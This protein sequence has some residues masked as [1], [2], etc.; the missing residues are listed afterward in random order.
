MGLKRFL[1]PSV[2]LRRKALRSGIFGGQKGWLGVWVIMFLW[3][4]IKGLFGFA[5]P[6]PVLIEDIG[7][8]Q[9][10]V[11]AHEPSTKRRKVRKATKADRKLE[12]KVLKAEAKAVR[13]TA[14]KAARRATRATKRIA[15]K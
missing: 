13:K 3:R 6:E 9:R 2:L 8:G 10:F 1:K 15:A 11:I 7:P 14:R 4:R 12:A 5:D